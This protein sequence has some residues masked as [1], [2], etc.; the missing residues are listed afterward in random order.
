[1]HNPYHRLLQ[2][3]I[4]AHEEHVATTKHIL[5]SL[6]L[7]DYYMQQLACDCLMEEGDEPAQD[8]IIDCVQTMIVDAHLFIDKDIVD[9]WGQYL[10]DIAEKHPAA[11]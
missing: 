10:I 6:I 5:S 4:E 1:M 7:D 8:E 2:L 11:Q 3:K 9:G